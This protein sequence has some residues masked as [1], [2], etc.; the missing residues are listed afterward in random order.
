MWRLVRRIG[1]LFGKSGEMKTHYLTWQGVERSYHVHKPAKYVPGN[2]AVFVLHGGGGDGLKIAETSDMA[3]EANTHGFL[4]VFPNSGNDQWNDG[5]ENV[6]PNKDDIGFLGAVVNDLDARMEIDPSRVALCGASNGG[7]MTH[8]IAYQFPGMFRAYATVVANVAA[9]VAST[10]PV[11]SVPMMMFN[12][13]ADR[14]MPWAGG[15]IPGGNDGADGGG[16]VTSTMAAV[17]AW[18]AANQTT[19]VAETLLPNLAALDG[20]RV[21]RRVYTG[22]L[23]P[24]TLY[25]VE[26]GGHTWPGSDE[27]TSFLVG[28]TTKDIKATKL[29]VEF[30]RSQGV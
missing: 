24:L 25:R 29:M 22:G 20:C 17:E 6:D 15:E 23:K 18:A 19:G 13:T 27:P 12:G 7:L 21:Y 2:G 3:I 1:G 10:A 4:A 14:L 16:T 9:G 30:F 11:A 26:G 8:R 28:R 5:R